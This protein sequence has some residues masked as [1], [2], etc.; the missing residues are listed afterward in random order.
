MVL[1]RLE[2]PFL[3]VTARDGRTPPGHERTPGRERSSHYTRQTVRM[4]RLFGLALAVVL[5]SACTSD[6]PAQSGKRVESPSGLSV[7]VP[8][9]WTT[10]VATPKRLTVFIHGRWIEEGC[11][12][13]SDLTHVGVRLD[14]VP[15]PLQ[16]A[17]D[18][19]GRPARFT[20]SSGTG[21]SSGSADQP[22]ESSSQVIRFTDNGQYVDAYVDFGVHAS[23]GDKA[24][25]Y[26]VL[27]SLRV[28]Q[29]T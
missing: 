7:V 21:A 6:P 12:S 28:L 19:D 14:L 29:G 25:A 3:T 9:G 13:R 26:A 22:C 1:A 16:N 20:P 10:D 18:F 17:E 23:K 8:H 4:S 24:S 11:A 2:E 15:I 5:V 27:N